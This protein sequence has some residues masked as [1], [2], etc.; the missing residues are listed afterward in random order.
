[1][2]KL[3]PAVRFASN[4]AKQVLFAVYLIKVENRLIGGDCCAVGLTGFTRGVLAGLAP[5]GS[6]EFTG[7]TTGVVIPLRR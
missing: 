1:M 7:S 2:A 4:V 5:L 6:S 3:S